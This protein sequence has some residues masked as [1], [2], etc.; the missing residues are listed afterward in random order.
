MQV[1]SDLTIPEGARL[2]EGDVV[3]AIVRAAARPSR[4]R[5]PSVS[6]AEHVVAP[7]SKVLALALRLAAALERHPED[8]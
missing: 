1:G 7:A 3:C 4:R 8:C 2:I 5:C 6:V